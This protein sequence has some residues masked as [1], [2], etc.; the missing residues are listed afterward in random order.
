MT[1]PEHESHAARRILDLLYL[2]QVTAQ[3]GE[4]TQTLP[5]DFVEGYHSAV[6]EMMDAIQWELDILELAWLWAE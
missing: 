1:H 2:I 3:L 6:E 5:A 4:E